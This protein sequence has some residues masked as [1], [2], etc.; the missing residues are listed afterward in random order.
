MRVGKRIAGEGAVDPIDDF[1]F[2]SIVVNRIDL[3]LDAGVVDLEG[4]L[5]ERGVRF[6]VGAGAPRGSPW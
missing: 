5:D 2:T 4:E 3:D 1:C 6:V